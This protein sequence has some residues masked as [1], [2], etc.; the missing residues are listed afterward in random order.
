MY[1]ISWATG[2]VVE[3]GESGLLCYSAVGSQKDSVLGSNGKTKDTVTCIDV[4]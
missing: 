1:N 2:D 3:G 4:L